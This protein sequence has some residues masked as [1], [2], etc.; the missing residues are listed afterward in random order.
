MKKALILIF[1]SL[2]L[3]A[4]PVYGLTN[5]YVNITGNVSVHPRPPEPQPEISSGGGGGHGCSLENETCYSD[6]DCCISK[7]LTCSLNV[8]TGFYFICIPKNFTLPQSPVVIPENETEIPIPEPEL[9]ICSISGYEYICSDGAEINPCSCDNN[10]LVCNP[11]PDSLCPIQEE[12]SGPDLTWLWIFPIL[13][14][15]GAGIFLYRK[16]KAN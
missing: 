8:S 14:A 1:V 6:S 13:G 10:I 15:A 2:L 12:E 7:N 4:I 5:E 9:E 3:T 16:R 11:E